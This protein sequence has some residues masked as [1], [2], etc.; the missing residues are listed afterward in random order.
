MLKNLG[1]VDRVLRL[2]L[3][4]FLVSLVFWGPRSIWGWLGIVPILTSLMGS[5]PLYIPFGIKTCSTYSDKKRL[6]K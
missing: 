1:T 6:L 4:L 5:C 3:G 2:V